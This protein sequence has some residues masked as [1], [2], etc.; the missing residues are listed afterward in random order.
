MPPPSRVGAILA[1]LLT[2]RGQ[3]NYH[4]WK[5]PPAEFIVELCRGASVVHDPGMNERRNWQRLTSH[6][7]P[8][9]CLFGKPL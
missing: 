8:S 2:N 9:I 1:M 3:Y 6:W 7:V 5:D 4:A